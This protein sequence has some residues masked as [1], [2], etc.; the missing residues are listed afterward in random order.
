M[1]GPDARGRR[2]SAAPDGPGRRPWM[3]GKTGEPWMASTAAPRTRVLTA[4]PRWNP[5]RGG[6]VGVGDSPDERTTRRGR[7]PR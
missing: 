7:R 4:K 6:S 2:F 3:A 1:D 5:S